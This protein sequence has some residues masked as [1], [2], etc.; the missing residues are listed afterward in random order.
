MIKLYGHPFSPNARKVHWTLEELELPYE[1]HTID[2]TRG[3]QK[4]AAFLAINPA[5][6]VPTLCD[7]DLTLPES[8]AIVTYLADTYGRGNIIPEDRQG[9]A[10]VLRWLFW[11]A[12]E[13][14]T[15]LSRPFYLK[16][17]MPMLTQQP[18]NEAA[19]EQARSDA[20]VPLKFLDQA[21]GS[22]S[23]LV[24]ERFSIADIV[25]GEAASLAKLAH[26]DFSPYG[27]LR[28]WLEQL[29]TRSA[30]QKSRPKL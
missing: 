15:A 30:F 6:K 5:G 11:Q 21:L 8:N 28:R 19:Y 25:T 9:H 18:V 4:S 12:A 3:E 20:A 2:L 24:G 27:N 10:W 1:Y 16:V 22:H 13:G 7:G 17:V 29:A 26:V 23:Y 14:S